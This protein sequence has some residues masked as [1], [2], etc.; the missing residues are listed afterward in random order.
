[1][2]RSASV[3]LTTSTD[4]PPHA[5]KRK[6]NARTHAIYVHLVTL[7]DRSSWQLNGRL[8]SYYYTKLGFFYYTSERARALLLAP[9]TYGLSVCLSVIG[10]P[11]SVEWSDLCLRHLH[12]RRQVEV[13][14]D[15]DGRGGVHHG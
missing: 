7:S 11:R 8:T 5:K 12:R 4:R 10:R 3:H 1:M 9:E 6:T 15:A 13:E 14:P 2:G